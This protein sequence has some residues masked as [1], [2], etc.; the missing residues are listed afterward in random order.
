ML[1]CYIDFTISRFENLRVQR[2]KCYIFVCER[3]VSV[4]NLAV[5]IKLDTYFKHKD[6]LEYYLLNLE[7]DNIIGTP[8]RKQKNNDY[9]KLIQKNFLKIES[10]LFQTETT[11]HCIT[12]ELNG[13]K[14]Y[15]AGKI[16]NAANKTMA[17]I[18]I[19]PYK[20]PMN[21]SQDFI[22]K[23]SYLIIY[24][25]IIV[26]IITIIIINFTSELKKLKSQVIKL[27]ID[28]DNKPAIEETKHI[29]E[30]DYFKELQTKIKKI[31]E[32]RE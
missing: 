20:T 5:L 12:T 17:V 27:K 7:Y 22:R 19:A 3:W 30:S 4:D 31:K 14:T 10:L 1:N 25:L 8:N 6:E 29:T 16:I 26:L 23:S 2:Q 18:G 15:A 21:F 24:V 13:K 9:Y 32:N 28:F 11:A